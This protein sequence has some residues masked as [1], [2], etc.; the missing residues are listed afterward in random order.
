MKKLLLFI[1]LCISYL[2]YSQ[3]IPFL[4]SLKSL[5]QAEA[6]AFADSISSIS[7]TKWEVYKID[8]T[9]KG[10]YLLV[11]YVNSEASKEQRAEPFFQDFLKITFFIYHEGENKDLE[12]A[13]VKKFRFSNVSGRYLDLFPAWKKYFK[14]EIE[15]EQTLTD[16]KSQKLKD[17]DNK[18]DF[19]FYKNRDI[20][21][22]TNQS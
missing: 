14:P 15:L 8:E 18:L 6:L 16:W 9:R 17:F 4:Q 1:V 13:G 11:Y 7:K 10:D 12:I 3:D 2:S 21:T 19:T 5:S 20:W 22:L